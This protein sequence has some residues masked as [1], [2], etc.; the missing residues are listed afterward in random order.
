VEIGKR[1]ALDVFRSRRSRRCRRYRRFLESTL[2][3]G[4]G[5]SGQESVLRFPFSALA[6]M[7]VRQLPERF[8]ESDW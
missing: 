2:N 6:A 7:S 4:A 1:L 3:S 5:W 8:L